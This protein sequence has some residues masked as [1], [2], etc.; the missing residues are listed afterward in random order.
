MGTRRGLEA[1]LLPSLG[2]TPFFLDVGQLKG[3]GALRRIKTLLT[4]PVAVWRAIKLCR[5]FKPHAVLGVGGYASAPVSV[6]ARLLNIPLFIHEQNALPGLTNRWLSR[7]AQG[8]L[9]SFKVEGIFPEKKITLTGNPV[10]E[11][12]ALAAKKMAQKK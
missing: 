6:A 9:L 8:I 3:H 11:Q 2:R 12:L 7:L 10:R 1:R 5:Q 4:L